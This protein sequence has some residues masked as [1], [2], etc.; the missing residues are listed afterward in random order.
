MAQ[1]SYTVTASLLGAAAVLQLMSIDTENTS[2]QSWIRSATLSLL[3]AVLG[4]S[5]RQMTALPS[6]AFCGIAFLV[7]GIRRFQAGQDWKKPLLATLLVVCVV[8]GALCTLREIEIN[9][10]D[11]VREY[12][13]WQKQR[14]RMI[15]YYD[16]NDIP[17]ETRDQY[18]LTDARLRLMIEWYLMDGDLN[19]E[20][21]RAFGD[22]LEAAEDHSLNAKLTKAAATL[23]AFPDNEPLAA[24]GLPVLAALLVLCT[25]SLMA[26]G[27][28]RRLGQL[29]GLGAGLLCF[30]ALLLYLASKGRL[31][32]RGMLTVALPFAALLCGLLPAY[33]PETCRLPFKAA[34]SVLAAGAVVLCA[35]YLIPM[36]DE[37]A[38]RPLSDEAQ[39]AMDTF[40]ALD[41]YG[42]CNEEYLLITDG[43]LSGDTRMFPTTEYGISTNII[44]WGGWETHSPVHNQL[45]ERYGFDPDQWS[46]GD[47]LNENVRLVSAGVEPS[48]LLLDGLNEIVEV[49]WYLDS[50][51]DGVYS[52]YFEEW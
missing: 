9:T 46:L 18:G 36:A 35:L 40:G 51:W 4:Y 1:V 37:I 32:M 10:K 24:K 44:S 43:T 38:R 16:L 5:M 42:V 31:P 48:P 28:R 39:A 50:E 33:L 30:A 3:M 2:N 19:T 17:Q 7:Q 15:D 27:R 20:T 29:T 12:V 45:L 8:F 14:I 25:A 22:A 26:G 34:G 11:D 21:L 6:M 41:D 13:D 47:F 23:K 52:L 49:D